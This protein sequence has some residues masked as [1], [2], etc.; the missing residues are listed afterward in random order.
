MP[1]TSL[2]Q[3]VFNYVKK[4]Y[5]SEIE[6]LWYPNYAAFRHVDNKKW[7]GIVMDVLR[8]KL[9]LSGD[10]V[11]DILIVKLD[12]LLLRDLL[13]QQDGYLPG[14]H[15]SRGNWISIL[16]DGTVPLEEITGLIDTSFEV[17]ASKKKK[18]E[19]EWKQG[20]GIKV[21]DT[22][23]MYVAAPVSAILF[24]CKVVATDIP[25]HFEDAA[26][27]IKALMKI[28]LQKRYKTDKFTFDRLKEEYG[29]FAVRGPRGI[30]NTLSE[31]LRKG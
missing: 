31:A 16:L 15:I 22:V 1:E 10:G 3:A 11:V 7:Y 13:I 9:G 19:I 25:C 14:Y 18:Q 29:I 5:K 20:S 21:G 8:S 26:I 17:T 2:R 30:P 23:F 12:D 24:K 28:R 27:T 6:Y 4:K